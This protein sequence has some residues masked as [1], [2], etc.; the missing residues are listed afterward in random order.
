VKLIF[1]KVAHFTPRPFGDL[2]DSD[3]ESVHVVHLIFSLILISSLSPWLH[4]F[5]LCMDKIHSESGGGGEEAMRSGRYY[6]RRE[7]KDKNEQI[8]TNCKVHDLSTKHL[9]A[10]CHVRCIFY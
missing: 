10:P 9:D 3:M 1:V 6:S 2:H 8:V 5:C 7:E 4:T